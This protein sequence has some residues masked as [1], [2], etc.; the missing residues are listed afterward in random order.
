MVPFSL[1][2]VKK[3]TAAMAGPLLSLILFSTL[4]YTPLL[5]EH[6]GPRQAEEMVE[7]YYEEQGWDRKTGDPTRIGTE[8]LGLGEFR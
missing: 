8:A 1:V 3:K 7:D 4:F 5:T 2:F 6:D